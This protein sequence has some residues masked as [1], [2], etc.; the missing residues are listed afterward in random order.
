MIIQVFSIND[1]KSATY[2]TPQFY[3]NSV[4]AMRS[5]QVLANDKNTTVGIFPDDFELYHIGEYDTQ[6]GRVK[7]FEKYTFVTSAK[8]LVRE[9]KIIPNPKNRK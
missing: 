9:E 5:L 4:H 3:E 2:S 1:K 8:S 6:S 7:M